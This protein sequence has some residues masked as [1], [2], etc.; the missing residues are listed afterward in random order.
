M[1][2]SLVEGYHKFRG[3]LCPRKLQETHT[4]MVSIVYYLK[5]QPEGIAGALVP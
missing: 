4:Q 2:R 1:L 3:T 5:C